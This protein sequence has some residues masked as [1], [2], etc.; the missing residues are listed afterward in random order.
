MVIFGVALIGFR[1]L[2]RQALS[3]KPNSILRPLK[4]KGFKEV[5]VTTMGWYDIGKSQDRGIQQEPLDVVA[6]YSTMQASSIQ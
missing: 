1:D 5:R 4:Q 6:S 2:L 3:E